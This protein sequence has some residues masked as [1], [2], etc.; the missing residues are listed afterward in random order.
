ME[1]RHD[2][3]IENAIFENGL[4]QPAHAGLTVVSFEPEDEDDN[5]NK[6]DKICRS[7]RFLN[8][9][10]AIGD[11]YQ[12]QRPA[13]CR[14]TLICQEQLKYNLGTGREGFWAFEQLRVEVRGS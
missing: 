6:G 5:A 14:P 10:V 7:V 9:C 11:K 4:H 1:C 2:E 8:I 12:L 3:E 13:T